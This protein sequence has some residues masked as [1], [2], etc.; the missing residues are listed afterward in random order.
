MELCTHEKAV[1]FL[2]VNMLTV[3]SLTFLTTRHATMCPDIKCVVYPSTASRILVL[4]NQENIVFM[5]LVL[6]TVINHFCCGNF[7]R[8]G[9]LPR[10]ESN[11]ISSHLQ[12][13]FSL[14]KY[15]HV[16][17]CSKG[18]EFKGKKVSRPALEV[19]ITKELIS[20]QSS[21]GSALKSL[22]KKV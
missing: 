8:I 18:K 1:F 14:P 13:Q 20:T 17:F 2:P 19:A 4:R 21:H 22:G 16:V 15:S 10:V 7:L 3:W 9:N 12:F 11:H 5:Y 6:Y